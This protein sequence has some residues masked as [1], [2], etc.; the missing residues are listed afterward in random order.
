MARGT[1]AKRGNTWY[2]AHRIDDPATGLRRQKWQGGFA[3]KAEAERGPKR[4]PGPT[5]LTHRTS[6][7]YCPGGGHGHN[8]AVGR[9]EV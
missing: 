8:F 9:G 2:Y 4:P 6:S 5:A 7:R 1:V 3:T